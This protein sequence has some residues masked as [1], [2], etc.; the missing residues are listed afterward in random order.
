MASHWRQSVARLLL[1]LFVFYGAALEGCHRQWNAL[2]SMDGSRLYATANGVIELNDSPTENALRHRP[3]DPQPGSAA[4][5]VSVISYLTASVHCG[6]ETC[7][8]ESL[9]AHLLEEGSWIQAGPAL[10]SAFLALPWSAPPVSLET[11][12][13]IPGPGISATALDR[14][15]P[16]AQG[17]PVG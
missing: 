13:V 1:V 14:Q 7:K 11:T 3:G 4:S 5:S 6:F 10:S 12:R 16:Y 17:P 15:L 8:P 9:L 2:E